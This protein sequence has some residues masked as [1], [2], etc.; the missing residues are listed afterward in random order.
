[1]M[2]MPAF[3]QIPEEIGWELVKAIYSKNHYSLPVLFDLFLLK[4]L[5]KNL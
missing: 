1:M 2:V 4:I 3:H 5:G